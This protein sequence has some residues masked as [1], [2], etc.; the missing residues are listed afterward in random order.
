MSIRTSREDVANARI[1]TRDVRILRREWREA[2][3]TNAK[4]ERRAKSGWLPKKDRLAA[5]RRQAGLFVREATEID[6]ATV[7]V[8]S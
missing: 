6:R 2:M 1:V 3:R 7:Q 4:I 5:E 8:T